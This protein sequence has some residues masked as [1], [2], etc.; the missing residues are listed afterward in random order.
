MSE[1][2][3]TYQ[4][5]VDFMEKLRAMPSC[6]H[7]DCHCCSA[8]HAFVYVAIATCTVQP[9]TPDLPPAVPRARETPTAQ[10]CSTELLLLA[11]D[12][13]FDGKFP[14]YHGIRCQAREGVVHPP[15]TSEIPCLGLYKNGGMLQYSLTFRKV[16]YPLE[17]GKLSGK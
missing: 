6:R 17:P 11:Q 14:R 16:T 1:A 10:G 8:I 2:F 12:R 13:M 4:R 9:P 3:T 15:Q 5:N 7:L